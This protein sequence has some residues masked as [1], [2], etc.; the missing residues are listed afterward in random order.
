MINN[1]LQVLEESLHKKMEVLNRIE[2]LCIRQEKMLRTEPVPEEEFDTSIDEKGKLIEELTRLDD[3]F[4]NLYNRIKE[5]LSGGK[6]KYR[7]QIA[8]LQQ[9]ITEVTDKSV[10]I[11]A[12]ETRNKALAETFFINRRKEIKSN[13][14]SSRAAIDYYRN[15]SQ[16]KV[17]D[18]Q[19]MDKKK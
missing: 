11:Q 12:K 2:E 7:V 18:P 6:E 1:Y 16:S 5:Q 19:F 10:S 13:R 14:R 3:G 15:M 8:V 9:L 4:E 17:V